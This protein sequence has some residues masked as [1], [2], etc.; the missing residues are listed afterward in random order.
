[1]NSSYVESKDTLGS[2]QSKEAAMQYVYYIRNICITK[3]K[4]CDRC[5]RCYN[6]DYYQVVGVFR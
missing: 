4:S 2:K 3:G 6:P 1:M 5:A